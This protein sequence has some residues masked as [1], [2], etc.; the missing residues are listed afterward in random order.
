MMEM[1]QIKRF[2]VWVAWGVSF[3]VKILPSFPPPPEIEAGALFSL[4]IFMKRQNL[5]ISGWLPFSLFIDTFSHA[6]KAFE[7][8][9][10]RWEKDS[11]FCFEHTQL[12]QHYPKGSLF[13]GCSFLFVLF[14]WVDFVWLGFF[15]HISIKMTACV[16]W[17]VFFF[18][19]E[20][21]FFF[22]CS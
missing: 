6:N 1:L 8:F 13:F 22:L 2:I 3:P 9:E 16:I 7:T 19:L 17:G 4:Y 10:Q 11:L 21:L 12:I 5:G 15:N 20:D 14:V 18:F